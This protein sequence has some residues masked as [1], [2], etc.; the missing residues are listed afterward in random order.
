[1]PAPVKFAKDMEEEDWRAL[2]FEVQ[3]T[4]SPSAPLD[5]TDLFAGRRVQLQKVLDATV[6]RGKHV[7]LFGERGVGKTSLAKL[8]YKLFPT[9]ARSIWS[10]REQCD[11]SD[12]FD[13]IWRKVFK[14]IWVQ[15]QRDGQEAHGRLSELYPQQIKPDDVRRE[16]EA[17]FKASEI[18][19]IIIDELD[20]VRDA[21]TR[22]LVA[23][24][25][26]HLSDYSVNV[27]VILVGVADDVN[28]LIGEH[29]S[30]GRC[31]E[32]VLM[33]RMSMSERREV[34][35]KI[36]PRLGMRIDSDALAKV[37]S[38]SRGLPSY[39]HS[40]GQSAALAAI[41]RRSLNINENDIDAAVRRVLEK[42][43]ESVQENYARAVHS[44]RNDNLYREVLL[45]CAMAETNDRGTFA[46]ASVC[47]PL[48]AILKREKLVEIAAFQQ[49]LQKFI[50]DERGRI[51]VRIGQERSYRYRFAD[52]M[53]QPYV[54]MKGVEQG[55]VDSKALE[56]LSSPA[57]LQ[58]PTL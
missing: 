7:I 27:T 46:P 2:G 19:I 50:T 51:L 4:F 11:P 16:L 32:Q 44:N 35:E 30:I 41:A 24:T 37:A 55:L 36:L 9:T 56:V 52:P 13:S 39:V 47:A 21:T 15:V 17:C 34:L 33:P 48:S 29:E 8:V 28:G 38:L 14:D 5:E 6:E 42:S 54:I 25:I 3:Q 43:E 22:G 20:K 18:P 58:L 23:N 57:Q 53:M 26:K 10:V 45:A 40:L 49:H 1:M 31:L 12:D